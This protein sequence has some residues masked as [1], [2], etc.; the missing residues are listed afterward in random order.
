MPGVLAPHTAVDDTDVD[1]TPADLPLAC[2]LADC[3]DGSLA[4]DH[5][6][7]TAVVGV[8]GPDNRRAEGLGVTAGIEL[9]SLL[10]WKRAM[11]TLD[12]ALACE[13][14]EGACGCQASTAPTVHTCGHHQSAPPC[15]QCMS[16]ATANRL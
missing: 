2:L 4:C 1:M 9:T 10:L 12:V 3:R 7:Q 11:P 6:T 14:V 5:S 16:A 15:R 8:G 13:W